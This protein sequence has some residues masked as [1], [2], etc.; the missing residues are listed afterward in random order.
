MARSTGYDAFISYSHVHDRVLGPALQSAL[1]R[2]AK[3]WYR[4]RALRVFLD[5]ANLTASP[6][7]WGS[8]ENA[9]DSS[10]WFVLL[11][12]ADA[13]KSPWV[14]REVRWW[15]EHRPLAR[16]LVVATG[17]GLSWDSQASDWAD[18]APVPPA[19]RGVLPG[20]PSWVSLEGTRPGRGGRLIPA[21][22]LASV[23]APIRG[24]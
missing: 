17:P 15:I 3:P 18:E 10:A 24:G 16:L 19:L 21:E 1:E 12:S 23:A 7:L 13:A 9:L 20:E 11:A 5:S 4:V 14:D 8:I 2:F 22:R 6:E